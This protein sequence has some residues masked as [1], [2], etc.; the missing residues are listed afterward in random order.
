MGVARYLTDGLRNLVANLG[1]SRDKA[2]GNH[3]VCVEIP[4]DQLISTYRGAW[5]PRKI[6]DIPALDSC[7]RWRNWQAEADQIT[8]IEAEEKRLQVKL[9]ILEART[10]A[11][12]MGGAAVFIGTKDRDHSQPLVP[13]AGKRIDYLTVMNRRVLSAGDME[14]DPLSPRYGKP[15]TYRVSGSGAVVDIH[16]TRLVTFVGA[17]NPDD[18]LATGM[19]FGWGDSALLAVIDAVKNADATAGNIASLIF[20]AK[21]DIIKIP[22]F[23]QGLADPQ[24]EKDVLNR[25]HLAATAKA[26]NGALLLDKEEEYEQKSANFANLPETLMAFLQIV[27]GAADIPMTRLL[28]QSPGG[29]NSTGDADLRNYY[30]RIQ[31]AQELEMSPAMSMLDE[32][33]IWGALGAR[34]A[35]VFYEWNS[36][37][38]TTAKERSDIGKTTAE[39]IKT[40]SETRLIP[41]EALSRTAINM[42]TESGVAPGLEAAVEEF[43]AELPGEEEPVDPAESQEE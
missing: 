10:K 41:E 8:K 40:L 11:R 1:T 33:L 26:I 9:K 3:Y 29:L 32:M 12:L 28:G 7:R 43:G 17:Q 14:R 4:D 20:E 27:S 16:H 13:G 5:L 36:L 25:L 37:W 35:E 23:M 42:M 21:I 24:Y 34:P 31:S 38:Q 6:V 22:Q 30:D 19:Q 18:E 39:T 2:A 15:V